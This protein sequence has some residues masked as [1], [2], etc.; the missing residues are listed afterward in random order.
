M[1]PQGAKRVSKYI[2]LEEH[3]TGPVASVLVLF[4][5]RS[6][7]VTWSYKVMTW[8]S[9]MCGNALSVKLD[10]NATSENNFFVAPAQGYI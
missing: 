10:K 1:L 5:I 6:H 9:S 8:F 3:V 7:N 4:E 2:I